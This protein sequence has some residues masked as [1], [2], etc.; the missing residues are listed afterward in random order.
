MTR[1]E[2]LAATLRG[3]A[4]AIGFAL[5]VALAVAGGAAAVFAIGS[6]GPF[7][8]PGLAESLGLAT[9]RDEVGGLLTRVETP[10][11]V[12]ILT[13]IAAVAVIGL[14]VGLIYG[15][16]SRSRPGVVV[17]SADQR[18]R[19]AARRRALER[20]A[21]ALVDRVEGVSSERVRVRP[22]RRGPGGRLTV[23]TSR[24]QTLSAEAADSS[25]EAA[26][27]PLA[28]ETQLEVTVRSQ[29]S[30]RAA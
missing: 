12:A 19:V 7:S 11:P 16:L 18:G 29:T 2:A 1:G 9:L 4:Q 22:A 20:I 6:Q 30:E 10:G 5:L 21:A 13:L 25:T 14:G 17:V 28:A 24:A 27:A 15:A 8:I 3:L 26:L 23:N